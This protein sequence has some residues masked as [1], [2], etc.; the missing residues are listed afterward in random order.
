VGPYLTIL[1]IYNKTSEIP[2]FDALAREDTEEYVYGVFSCG[3]VSV[4]DRSR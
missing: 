4:W 3:A 1:G 2:D